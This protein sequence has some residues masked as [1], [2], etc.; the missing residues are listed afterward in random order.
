MATRTD[1]YR[2]KAAECAK[3]ALQ[4]RNSTMKEVYQDV[5]SM[6]LHLAEQ[7]NMRSTTERRPVDAPGHTTGT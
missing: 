2:V 4:A 6:W 7:A 5:A 3:Q 1:E